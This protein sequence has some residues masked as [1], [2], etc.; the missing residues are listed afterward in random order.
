MQNV[1]AKRSFFMSGSG[2]KN[3]AAASAIIIILI[4]VLAGGGVTVLTSETLQ[5]EEV[6]ISDQQSYVLA[7]GGLR[8]S[9]YLLRPAMMMMKVM[10]HIFPRGCFLPEAMCSCR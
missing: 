7:L 4:E 9:F 1:E 6:L 3:H 10:V 8:G 5:A 2:D